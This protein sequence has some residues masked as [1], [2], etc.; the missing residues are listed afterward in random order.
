MHLPLFLKAKQ[1]Y[2]LKRSAQDGTISATDAWNMQ[3][4]KNQANTAQTTMLPIL[5]TELKDLVTKEDHTSIEETEISA[6]TRDVSPQPGVDDINI[7]EK[8]PANQSI[9]FNHTISLSAIRINQNTEVKNFCRLIAA[10]KS[11]IEYFFYDKTTIPAGGLWI[12]LISD[13]IQNSRTV[14]CILSPQYSAS[15]VCWDEFQCAKAK[16]IPHQTVCNKNHQFL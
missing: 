11:S 14:I 15:D 3:Q 16:R 8:K 7:P 2:D 12:K 5:E 10:E 6:A 4:L 9:I 13:A 1:Q